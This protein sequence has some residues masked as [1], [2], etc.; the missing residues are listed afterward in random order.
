M[1]SLKL[2][3]LLREY[4]AIVFILEGLRDISGTYI[5]LN[6]KETNSELAGYLNYECK[7]L[8]TTV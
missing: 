1:L 4:F 2:N 8:N 6:A 3:I 7:G 5:F